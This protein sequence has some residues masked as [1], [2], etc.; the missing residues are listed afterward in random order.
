MIEKFKTLI[1]IKMIIRIKSVYKTYGGLFLLGLIGIPVGAIIGLIDTIFGTVLLKVTDIRETYPMYLIPFLAVVGVV[2]AYCYFKFGGKSSK[3]MNLIFEVGHGEEEIIPLRLV[4]FIISGTWLT[5]LFGG[6]AGR[7][8]V[9]VQIGATF[10]HWVGK[11]LPIKNA[12]S[13]FLVTGMAA[14][15]AGLFET[16]IAAILFAMEVLVA[17]SLE[18]Q[19]LF[20]AFTAS[21]TAS[22]VSKALGLEKFSFALSSK[23]VFD[24]SIFW[25]LIVL[26]IIFGMVGGAFAWCLKLSKRKIGNRLKNP[27][28]RIAII[29]VCLS[30]LFLLFY[31]GRYSGLGT[32]LI[33][34]SFYGGEIYSFDWL[35]KFILTILTLSAGFQGGEVT[36]LF[37]IGASIGVLL[38]GFFNLPIE[39]VA[40]LGYASVFGSATN[41]FFAPVFIGAEVFGYSYLPYFFVVC[42]ISYIFNM[43]K[44]IYSL[45]KIS[46]KQ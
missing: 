31:K 36:P 42:A 19:S 7:E 4:P 6:S 29:G 22:S 35:L 15:F 13:I 9:A 39:L 26:G 45:Q 27:M 46:T 10:S 16:P 32:N 8:G 28:I 14:G 1:W 12:S 2:I 17:G 38:A 20:P 34:N 33:Q 30:V 44:S 3:G 11:R 37:S 18:Y 43:D 5:H 25:K 40:A 41:T 21:F 23:V 24:L